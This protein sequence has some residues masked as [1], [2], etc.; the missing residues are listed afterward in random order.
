MPVER[1]QQKITSLFLR[2]ASESNKDTSEISKLKLKTKK[3]HPLSLKTDI[4]I[5]IKAIH[6][7]NI[8][9]RVKNHEFRKYNI[10][11]SIERMWYVDDII[12]F[13]VGA[14]FVVTGFIHQLQTNTC[15]TLL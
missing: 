15:V 12:G 5:S 4:V 6:M 11:S 2:N 3:K 1:R 7:D 14:Y 8:V 9:S 10:S 13:F